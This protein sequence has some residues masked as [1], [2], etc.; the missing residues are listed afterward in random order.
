[1]KTLALVTTVT[2][3]VVGYWFA[4]PLLFPD[5]DNGLGAGLTAFALLAVLAVVGGLWDGFHERRLPALVIRWLL[6]AAAVGVA[7]PVLV[8]ADEGL[9]TSVLAEDIASTVPFMMVLIGLPALFFGWLGWM[10]QGRK[11]A[12]G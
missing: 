6:V 4:A 8:W 3:A 11:R 2:A 1:M 10:L 5:D 9:T 7:L 12:T